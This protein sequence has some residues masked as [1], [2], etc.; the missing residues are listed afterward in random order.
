MHSEQNQNPTSPIKLEQ[1]ELS[2]CSPIEPEV[3]FN[4]SRTWNQ[5]ELYALAA[6]LFFN[7]AKFSS[8]KTKKKWK[9][10]KIMSLFV[11]TRN[12][13]QCRTYTHKLFKT[14]KDI[15]SI[16]NFLRDSLPNYATVIPTLKNRNLKI[17]SELPLS[18]T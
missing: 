16:N 11:Q 5:T 8:E 2:D 10:F 15:R 6:F 17:F 7:A 4:R 12:I 3:D 9:I 1:E 18:D 13:N 14:F